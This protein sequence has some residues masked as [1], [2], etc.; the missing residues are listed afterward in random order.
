MRVSNE[1]KIIRQKALLSQVEFADALSVSFSTVNRW[2]TGKT[3]PNMVAMR[4]IKQF[5]EKNSISI[6]ALQQALINTSI[7]DDTKQSD[8]K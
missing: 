3:V 8:T 2:E 4:K 1:I 5:C 6:D 7:T